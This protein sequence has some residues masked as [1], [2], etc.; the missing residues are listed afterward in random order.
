ME[1]ELGFIEYNTSNKNYARENRK[2]PTKAEN[3]VWQVLLRNKQMLGY[4]FSRQKP[5]GPFI[6]DFYCAKLKLA[7]EID[8]SSHDGREE[9]DARRTIE[10]NEL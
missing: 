9:Y 8:G 10:L 7:I 4:K 2:N 6:V 1:K 3:I 5:L